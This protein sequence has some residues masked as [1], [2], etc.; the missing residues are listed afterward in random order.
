MIE[1]TGQLDLD[2]RGNRNFHGASS[3]ALFL[4]QMRK[5]LGGGCWVRLK[6][7]SYQDRLDIRA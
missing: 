1:S 3:A 7:L 6:P 5:Q 2:D 4:R